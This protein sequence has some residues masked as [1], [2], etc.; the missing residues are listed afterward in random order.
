LP[1]PFLYIY[2]F[3]KIAEMHAHVQKLVSVVKM[4]AVLLCIF[5]GQKDS[6]QRIFIKK[7]F[8]FMVGSV[9]SVKRFT[10]VSRNSL[11]DV[12]K[13]QMMPGEVAET[14]VK[15]LQCC[16]FRRTGKAIGQVYRC[17]L[18][19]CREINVFH[20]FEYHVFYVLYP[21]VTYSLTL[22]RIKREYMVFMFV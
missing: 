20:R 7:C 21:Y 11:K 16:G 13:S 12:R 3:F 8:L 5:C 15:R 2:D 19:I 17:W 1:R 9:C 18:K 22:P 10:T 4:V 14:T 6:M